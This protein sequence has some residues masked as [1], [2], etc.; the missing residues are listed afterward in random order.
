MMILG[1]LMPSAKANPTESSERTSSEQR[2]DIFILIFLF[3]FA[4]NLCRREHA[5][6][7]T[8]GVKA[9]VATS[10]KRVKQIMKKD[11]NKLFQHAN[12]CASSANPAP[13]YATRCN[14][15][16]W[17]GVGRRCPTT[18]QFLEKLRR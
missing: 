14:S 2:R 7:A 10:P 11:L 13:E 17:C 8:R 18:N 9:R 1:S 5:S 15:G 6:P 12:N 16:A 3:F 4:S